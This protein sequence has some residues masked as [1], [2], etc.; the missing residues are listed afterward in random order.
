VSSPN[1]PESDTPV[2]VIRRGE[3]VGPRAESARRQPSFPNDS[4]LKARQNCDEALATELT[5]IG[6]RDKG[7]PR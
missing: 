1:F 7:E 2:G 3:T 6:R 5:G 4:C